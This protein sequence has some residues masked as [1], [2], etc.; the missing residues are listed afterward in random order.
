MLTLEFEGQEDVELR[1]AI[2][3]QV[4]VGTATAVVSLLFSIMPYSSVGINLIAGQ[5]GIIQ[6]LQNAIGEREVQRTFMQLLAEIDGFQPLGNIKIIGCTN[7]KDILDTAITRPGRLDRLIYVPLPD[8]EARKEIFKIHSQ[9]VKFDKK[10][11]LER[12]TQAMEGF[13]GA[14]IKAVVTEAGYFAIRN[15]RKKIT[16]EDLFKAVEKVRTGEEENSDYLRMF[17]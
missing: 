3:T 11:D 2:N 6:A 5:N 14:E 13:S 15:D 8:P 1:H 9:N 16:E 4:K 7:R 17:G 12:L 10:I